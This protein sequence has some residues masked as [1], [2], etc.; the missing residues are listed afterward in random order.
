M[1][2]ASI[3]VDLNCRELFGDM[4][5]SCYIHRCW[6]FICTVNYAERRTFL[7]TIV[8]QRWYNT[9]G[10]AVWGTVQKQ[11]HIYQSSRSC[12]LQLD[13]NMSLWK[14]ARKYFVFVRCRKDVTA[15]SYF[16][17]WGLVILVQ[18]KIKQLW[19]WLKLGEWFCK[20]YYNDVFYGVIVYVSIFISI[21]YWF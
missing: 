13:Y 8:C 17:F 18:I 5:V 4:D 16:A 19:K 14:I 10:L 6:N 15:K 21:S 7:P 3:W 12:H 11:R 20:N 9:I 1:F 2:W